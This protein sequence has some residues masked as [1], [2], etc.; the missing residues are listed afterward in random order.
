LCA[1]YLR[2]AY[3]WLRPCR[4]VS[5]ASASPPG[6]TVRI[7]LPRQVATFLHREK[8]LPDPHKPPHQKDLPKLARHQLARIPLS[9]ARFH[10]LSRALIVGAY[11]MKPYPRIHRVPRASGPSLP[12]SGP[13]SLG[14]RPPRPSRSAPRRRVSLSRPALLALV[15]F[16][17]LAISAV[18]VRPALLGTGSGPRI[19]RTPRSH[20]VK[21]FLLE[22]PG[23]LPAVAPPDFLNQSVPNDLRK[24]TA[25][26]C[27]HLGP[28]NGQKRP[29]NRQLAV[30]KRSKRPRFGHD[31]ASLRPPKRT[32]K[33]PLC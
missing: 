25:E 16:A 3:L 11:T 23:I 27:G 2:G 33:C 15:L 22:T 12:S 9:M 5:A 26:E 13:R 14:P 30:R 7:L 28:R 21:S 32:F 19:S 18:K 8:K 31:F 10:A 29:W 6:R 20:S 4:A 1:S 17:F 24:V